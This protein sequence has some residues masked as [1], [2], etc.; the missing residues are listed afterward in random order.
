[1]KYW[2]YKTQRASKSISRVKN[3]LLFKLNLL[4]GNVIYIG[5]YIRPLVYPYIHLCVHK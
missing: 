2:P 3:C 1:M 5:S 4:N